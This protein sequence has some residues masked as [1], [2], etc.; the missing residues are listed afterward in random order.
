MF[1]EDGTEAE[2]IGSLV[3]GGR[4][5]A[6]KRTIPDGASRER[7]KSES[8]GRCPP[9]GS[10]MILSWVINVTLVDMHVR[11]R[12]VVRGRRRVGEREG[13][14]TVAGALYAEQG[15]P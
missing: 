7:G 5:P 15:A 9:F 10:V 1:S 6:F 12:R 11:R 2:L 13:C 3:F 4:G 8:I 14:G